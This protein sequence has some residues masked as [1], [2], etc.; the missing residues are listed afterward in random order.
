MPEST[1]RAVSPFCFFQTNRASISNEAVTTSVTQLCQRKGL[2]ASVFSS[3][4]TLHV[5]SDL[6]AHVAWAYQNIYSIPYPGHVK[7]NGIARYYHGIQHVTRAANYIPVFANL[8]KKY[9]NTVAKNLTPDVLKLL[10]IAALFHDSAREGEGEDQW[11]HES[12]MLLYVYLTR[13]L[14]VEK[15]LACLIAEATANKDPHADGA[16]VLVEDRETELV[17]RRA[18]GHELPE[19]QHT[20]EYEL[21]RDL[22][23]DV[24]CLEILRA[25]PHINGTYLKFYQKIAKHNEE[26]LD[27]MAQLICEARSLIAIQGDSFNLTQSEVKKQFEH[28]AAQQTFNLCVDEKLH[29]VVSALRQELLTLVEFQEVQLVDNTP[30]DPAKGITERNLQSA[31]QEGK[32]FARAVLAPSGISKKLVTH[33]D[34]RKE[35]ETML[36]TELRKV[37]RRFGV[38]TTSSK[39]DRAKKE[40]NPN[41]STTNLAKGVGVFSDSGFLKLAESK[42]LSSIHEVNAATSFGKKSGCPIPT[43][44]DAKLAF[45]KLRLNQKFGGSSARYEGEFYSNHNECEFGLIKGFDAIFFSN[46]PTAINFKITRHAQPLHPYVPL[47]KAWYIKQFCPELDIFEYS[48]VHS[49]LKFVPKSEYSETAILRM[50]ITVYRDYIQY[51]MDSSNMD[52]FSAPLE[53]IK[54]KAFYGRFPNIYCSTFSSLDTPLSPLLR[55]KIDTEICSYIEIKKRFFISDDE[56]RPSYDKKENLSFILFDKVQ[57]GVHLLK[58]SDLDKT[59]GLLFAH[60]ESNLLNAFD[61]SASMA[62]IYN[63]QISRIYYVAKVLNMSCEQKI[64]RGWVEKELIKRSGELAR[65]PK[66]SIITSAVLSELERR[67]DEQLFL[68]GIMKMF[69]ISSASF[70]EE[71]NVF[72]ENGLKWT[73]VILEGQKIANVGETLIY[74][75]Y[76][77]DSLD[78]APTQ[79]IMTLAREILS[80][81]EPRLSAPENVHFLGDYFS[82]IDK[83]FENEHAS[84]VKR[85]IIF[86]LLSPTLQQPDL[87]ANTIGSLLKKVHAIYPLSA[88][89]IF[90]HILFGVTEGDFNQAKAIL[91]LFKQVIPEIAWESCIETSM[92]SLIIQNKLKIVTE[93]IQEECDH[94]VSEISIDLFVKKSSELITVFNFDKDVG[95]I[96]SI[97]ERKQASLTMEAFLSSYIQRWDEFEKILKNSQRY[98]EIQDCLQKVS[99]HQLGADN[100]IRLLEKFKL[101]PEATFWDDMAKKLRRSFLGKSFRLRLLKLSECLLEIGS[102][103]ETQKHQN[104]IPENVV[105][106]INE[107]L[108]C[109]KEDPEGIK[110]VLSEEESS[111]FSIRLKTITPL[112]DNIQ[113]LLD[114]FDGEQKNCLAP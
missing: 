106:V 91:T 35:K 66:D 28:E 79:L 114:A 15:H 73:L 45:K 34:G 72:V 65:Y 92:L 113:P 84:K 7:Q 89:E 70:Q 16:F 94:S 64:L 10:Q 39:E 78:F 48:G 100:C 88:S 37:G 69:D 93:A 40:G 38:S 102:Y 26:A 52:I 60:D 97:S 98:S 61:K 81:L 6:S 110:E 36:Q 101:N 29:P 27:V 83:F 9:D 18:S 85:E 32:L 19:R 87:N 47:L 95:G 33:S 107:W 12:A 103:L 24:D 82:F 90:A 67:R 80:K 54:V 5:G 30:F 44:S 105:T 112:R 68:V 49:F 22:I 25:R 11:D 41:R 104:L 58:Q 99:D 59:L 43:T 77:F 75:R 50:F 57:G 56:L 63:T 109:L 111:L 53:E 1:Q 14:G 3:H 8:F 46:D 108:E 42:E 20:L 76:I 71:W 74:I 23:H 13:V 62:T 86:E 31:M 55:N 51:Q 96:L 21:Y 2:D 17:W 4:D